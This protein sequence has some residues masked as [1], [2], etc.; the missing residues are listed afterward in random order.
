M[1]MTNIQMDTT[2]VVT[3]IIVMAALCL[4]VYGVYAY[5][6]YKLEG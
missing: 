6:E 3:A 1:N 5:K 4:L 2:D